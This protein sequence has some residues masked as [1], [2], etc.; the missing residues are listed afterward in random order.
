MLKHLYSEI[1]QVLALVRVFNS[2]VRFEFPKQKT[3]YK[4]NTTQQGEGLAQYETCV[5]ELS[6]KVV[7]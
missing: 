7:T 6:G 5:T 1:A 3:C 2:S 4:G